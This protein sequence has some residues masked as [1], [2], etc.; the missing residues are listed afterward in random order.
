MKDQNA[1]KNDSV[2]GGNNTNRCDVLRDELKMVNRNKDTKKRSVT[3]IGDSIIKSI[4]SHKMRGL[5]PNKEKLF[6]RSFPGAMID[7]MNDYMNQ[8]Y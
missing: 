3:I 5:L 6:I 7:D 2:D 1:R 8:T 4:Q